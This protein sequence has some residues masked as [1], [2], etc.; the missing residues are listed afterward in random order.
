[1]LEKYKVRVQYVILTDTV[2]NR[3]NTGFCR[4]ETV[5]QRITELEIGLTAIYNKFRGLQN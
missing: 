4:I 2:R 1:M 3:D 5:V